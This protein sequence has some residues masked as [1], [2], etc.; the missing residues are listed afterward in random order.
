M[1]AFASPCGIL[2]IVF[3]TLSSLFIAP[4]KA[5][6]IQI[7]SILTSDGEIFP[8]SPTD[9]IYGLSITGTVTLHSDTSLVRVILKDSNGTEWMIFE[10]YPFL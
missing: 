10:T 3:L 2:A 5:Q 9:T 6:T 4:M 7:D 8:F 1:K